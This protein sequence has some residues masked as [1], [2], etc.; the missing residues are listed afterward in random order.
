LK[1]FLL[2]FS[3]FIFS[4]LG[5]LILFKSSAK[6]IAGKIYPSIEQQFEIQYSNVL[7]KDFDLLILGNSRM[8]NAINPDLITIK[9][10]NFSFASDSYDIEFSKLK[11]LERE[12][13]ISFKY[14]ILGTDYFQFSYSNGFSNFF[15]NY[16][17]DDEIFYDEE[18]EKSHNFILSDLNDK[19]NSFMIHNFTGPFNIILKS[20][21]A[22]S[23]RDITIA[24][25]KDNGQ[26][27][28]REA[29]IG[30]QPIFRN[31]MKL[32]SQ[33]KYFEKI[34]EFSQNN[35]I[36]LIL[37]IPPS[38]KEELENYSEN[39]K[40]NFDN[41]IKLYLEKYSNITFLDYSIAPEISLNDYIDMTHL[42]ADGAD[43][44]TKILNKDIDKIIH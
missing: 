43:K 23:G 2:K 37:I 4:I 34:L 15:K 28:I 5:F 11:F 29:P 26:L 44:F 41:F 22:L 9:S 14:I 42:N 36:T 19:F 13:K 38:T 40:K 35:N 17:S 3:V 8:Q 27:A 30:N 31:Q 25:Q 12:K 21:K 20:L 32:N 39:D 6:H 10:F 7:S 16:L 24:I 33:V 1:N 18:P